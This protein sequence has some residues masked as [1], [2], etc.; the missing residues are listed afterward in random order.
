MGCKATTALSNN[1]TAYS[2]FVLGTESSRGAGA[3]RETGTLGGRGHRV[4]G[5]GVPGDREGEEAL[6]QDGQTKASRH[7]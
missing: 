5:P 7:R 2:K 4:K 3:P 1:L 6:G